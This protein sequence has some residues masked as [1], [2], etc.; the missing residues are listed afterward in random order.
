VGKFYLEHTSAGKGTYLGANGVEA[1]LS[2][3]P[4]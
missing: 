2:L 1:E 3:M 4:N